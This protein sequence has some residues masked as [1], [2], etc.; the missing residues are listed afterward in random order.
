M[1]GGWFAPDGFKGSAMTVAMLVQ[2]AYGLRAA[3][4]VAGGPDWA[5]SESYDV[6]AKMTAD[7]IAGMKNFSRSE[8]TKR[9]EQM[10]QALLAERF[11]LKTHSEIRQVPVYELVVAKGGTKIRDAATDTTELRKGR[12]GKPFTGIHEMGA[13]T[14]VVQGYSMKALAD[15]VTSIAFAN[16]RPVVDKTGLTGTYNFTL[17]WSIYA[18]SARPKLED[19]AS[20]PAE[21]GSFLATALKEVGLDL[22]P[23]K[24]G[25]EYIVIDHVEKPTEN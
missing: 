16:D 23:S 12:D 3:I 11:K 10:L 1:V 5:R 14:S 24:G 17:N 9:N 21:E 6:E 13:T 18:R 19:G 7:D 4:Q 20:D 22:H 15:Y 25:I 2:S 8:G